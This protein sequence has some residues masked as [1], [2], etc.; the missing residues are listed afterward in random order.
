MNLNMEIEPGLD[1]IDLALYIKYDK[2]L[3]F[4]DFHLGYE[5]ALNKQGILVPRHQFD[6]TIRRLNSI[7]AKVASKGYEVDTIVINGDLKHEFGT[8]SNQE[9]RDTIKLLDYLQE[10]CRKIVLVRGNNDKV[11]SY[12]E[13]RPKRIDIKDYH[14]THNCSI[15]HGDKIPD[16]TDALMK[17]VIIIGHEHPA[18]KISDQIMNVTAKCWLLGNWSGRALIVQPSFNLVTE[19][20]DLVHQKPLSPFLKNRSLGDFEILVIAGTEKILNFGKLENLMDDEEK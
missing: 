2:T 3:V 16:S 14:L 8:I 9:W 11:L 19:G 12:I 1:I 6:D 20:T 13:G 5:E 10:K 17:K 7:F 4:S 18:A 15:V